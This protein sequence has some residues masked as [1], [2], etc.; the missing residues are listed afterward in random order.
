MAGQ[1]VG[2]DNHRR[3]RAL[4]SQRQ[5]HL[6]IAVDTLFDEHES[7]AMAQ[8]DLG[9]RKARQISQFSAACLQRVHSLWICQYGKRRND[10]M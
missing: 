2:D 5:D 3:V 7:A 10:P 1:L 9:R 8:H 4:H 6:I